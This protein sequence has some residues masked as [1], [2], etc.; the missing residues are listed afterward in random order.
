M[1]RRKITNAERHAF[2]V[3]RGKLEAQL[4]IKEKTH[5][6]EPKN[7][8]LSAREH[9]G[10][11]IDTMTFEDVVDVVAAMGLTTI[12]HDAI[13]GIP[14]VVE[15]LKNTTVSGLMSIFGP[16]LFTSSQGFFDLIGLGDLYRKWT[17]PSEPIL[18]P[19][20]DQLPMF[21]G[22]LLAFS[23]AW[24]IIKWG[25]KLLSAGIGTLPAIIKLLTVV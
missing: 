15:T 24:C 10:K 22:W 11:L 5:K 17:T 2:H 16:N 1:P 7:L 13:K 18:K 9:I 20:E 3:E 6:I 25:D 21:L 14:E 23:I 12:I 8:L 4:V 19:Q